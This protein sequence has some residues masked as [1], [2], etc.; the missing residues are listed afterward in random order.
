MS[1]NKLLAFLVTEH[2]V[3]VDIVGGMRHGRA[4]LDTCLI[5]G[6]NVGVTVFA[7]VLELLRRPAATV[8]ELLRKSL[9]KRKRGG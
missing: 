8:Y 1:A 7:A 2:E 9:I 5:V 4:E 3:S 6:L